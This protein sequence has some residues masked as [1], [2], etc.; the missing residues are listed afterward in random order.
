MDLVFS[1]VLM[2][3]ERAVVIRVGIAIGIAVGSAVGID[4]GRRDVG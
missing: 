2:M 4:V 1:L 3:E